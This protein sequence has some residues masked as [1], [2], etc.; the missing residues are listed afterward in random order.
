[1]TEAV[2]V[3]RDGDVFQ[4]RMFWMRAARLLLP[5]AA[6]KRVAFEVGPRSFD[7][8]WV[9]YEPGRGQLDQ[10]G[11]P[12]RR[13]HI[14]CKWHVSPGTFGFA[15][16]ADPEFIH[17]N[18]RSLLQRADA[19]WRA[20]S[21]QGG[22][23]RFKL[24]TNWSVSR[25][26]PLR[27]MIGTRSGALR[28]GR[29][30]DGTTARS[31]AG[32]VRSLWRSHLDLDED[33]LRAFA[34]TL[35]FGQAAGSLD[36]LREDL[37]MVFLMAGLRRI[38]A[39]QSNFPY[40]DLIFQWMGQ[41]R[42]EFDREGFR[43]ACRREGM[44]AAS[45]APTVTYGVKSF[46]HPIDPLETRCAAVLDLTPLFEDRFI[47]DEADWTETISPR[48]SAFLLSAAREHQTLRLALDAHVSLAFA[49]GSI[50]DV[51]CGREVELEQRTTQRRI[52]S[53]TDQAV[54][55]GW[56]A[57]TAEIVELDEGRSGVAVA[58]AFTHDMRDAVTTYLRSALPDVGRLLVLRPTDGANSM[59]VQ[60][61]AHA[62]Q[63]AERC[64]AEIR[65][66]ASGQPVHLF[67]AAPNALT[68]FLGQ[69][70][71]LIGPAVLYEF[72]F[73]QVQGGS[74]RRSLM[75]PSRLQPAVVKA[76]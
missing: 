56:P 45:P 30:F 32:G 62:F 53:A 65:A 66:L 9:E 4:A 39:N 59:S 63:M 76:S 42:Q 15:D 17:A 11:N 48:L 47:R 40:D 57:L 38:P 10:N 8:I 50:L 69:R 5:E 21:A 6:I 14:Q 25:E 72:D 55:P 44:L 34:G 67:I 43:D 2:T 16:L 33:A 18:S 26:D 49:A 7:D 12:L 20:A 60:C 51:K 52:W 24:L 37:D 29:L 28:P 13:E 31:K 22:G 1:M 64:A 36:D 71:P 61:G 58:I 3:R 35:A 75:L 70:R 41:G 46:E 54:D 73:E 68:F 19:A 23:A 27:P 74:Y